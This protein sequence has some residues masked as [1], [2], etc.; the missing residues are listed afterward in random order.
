M[1]SAAMG[2]HRQQCTFVPARH[3][4][5]WQRHSAILFLAVAVLAGSYRSILNA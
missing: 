5:T 3:I 1:M 2:P 4:G